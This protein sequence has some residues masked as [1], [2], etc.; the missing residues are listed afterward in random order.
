VSRGL[1]ERDDS[2]LV[3]AD[4]QPG[5]YAYERT[6]AAESAE[7]AATVERIVRTAGMAALLDIPAVVVEEGPGREGPT[8]R[9][10]PRGCRRAR[11]WCRSRRSASRRTRRPSRR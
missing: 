8:D 6:D 4:T 1:I 7:A 9:G 10:S 2:V 3:V 5:F 11:R